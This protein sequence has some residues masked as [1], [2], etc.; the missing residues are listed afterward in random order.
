[1]C[2]SPRPWKKTIRAVGIRHARLPVGGARERLQLLDARAGLH[3]GQAASRHR[4][5]RVRPALGVALGLAVDHPGLAAVPAVEIDRA[6]AVEHDVRA[7]L[8]LAV[9]EA[10]GSMM[11]GVGAARMA[12][13]HAAR[14]AHE[15]AELGHRA[16]VGDV[17]IAPGRALLPGATVLRIAA[18]L[19]RVAR[20]MRSSSAG[21]LMDAGEHH[22]VVAV[23]DGRPSMPSRKPKPWSSKATL[24]RSS[25]SSR[26]APLSAL[27]MSKA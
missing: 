6:V 9:L 5:G 3:G 7:G 16:G 8:D 14:I 20:R 12:P 13:D 1:M 15:A 21:V 23:G 11:V 26:S 18:S 17:E 4:R 25:F 24:A 22:R 19:S 2:E 27:P 10:G